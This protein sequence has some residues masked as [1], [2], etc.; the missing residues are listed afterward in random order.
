MKLAR[1]TILITGGTG[2]IGTELAKQLLQRG[3]T[4]I[5]TGRDRER[6][7]VAKQAYGLNMFQSD[8]GDPIAIAK[9]REEVL[10]K[11]P[12]LDT[13]INGAGIMRKLKLDQDRDLTDLVRE[14]EINLCGPVRM[15]QQFLPHL[16]TRKDALIVN[17]SS[18]LAFVPMPVAPIYCAT[19]AAIHSYTQSLREQ[20]DGTG[21]RVVEL[22]PP[23]IETPMLQ[24]EFAEEKKGMK[25][26]TPEA[27][28]RHAIAAIESGKLEIRP[29]QSNLLKLMSRIAPGLAL[30]MLSMATKSK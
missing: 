16:E 11:F 10:A 26:M 4:V 1:R 25:T 22:A 29:G 6:L 8:V 21:V 5:I 2:G 15:I 13:L 19:K 23:G 9:L 28:A 24:G 20:L 27:L 3:N 7:E 17:I 14:I 18:A 30:K 12:G